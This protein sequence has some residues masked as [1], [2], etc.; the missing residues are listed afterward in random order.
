MRVR[1]NPIRHIMMK[2]L[3][4]THRRNYLRLVSASINISL[5]TYYAVRGN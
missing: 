1:V 5:M 2:Q 4:T 3:F